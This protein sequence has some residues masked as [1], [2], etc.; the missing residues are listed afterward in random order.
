MKDEN[1][2]RPELDEKVPFEK[3]V[4]PNKNTQQSVHTDGSIAYFKK[5]ITHFDIIP[6]TGE[7]DDD[8]IK[9]VTKEHDFNPARVVLI[10]KDATK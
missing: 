3:K 5:G 1:Y 4:D 8:A 6:K 10:H 2:S 7:S 9:R